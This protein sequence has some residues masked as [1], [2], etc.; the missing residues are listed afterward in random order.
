MKMP[1]SLYLAQLNEAGKL[2]ARSIMDIMTI[3]LT[4]MEE[5]EG[6]IKDIKLMSETV[7]L[8]ET[9]VIPTTN[10]IGADATPG[11]DLTREAEIGLAVEEK[12]SKLYCAN[13][14][15]EII[16]TTEWKEKHLKECKHEK[17]PEEPQEQGV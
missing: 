4:S 9:P 16:N 11:A 7:K 17:L 5:Q 10:K 15:T 8:E 13:C 6:E 14:G 3:V 1:W 12:D 2:T